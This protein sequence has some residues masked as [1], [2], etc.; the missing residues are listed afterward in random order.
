[1]TPAL[2]RPA[3]PFISEAKFVVDSST[4]RRIREW[5]RTHLDPDPH[6]AGPFGDEYGISSLYFDT[7]AG[8]V[9]HRRGSFGRAKYRVRRYG[10]AEVAFLERKLRKPGILSKRR[11]VVALDALQCLDRHK[12]DAALGR[13]TGSIGAC[14]CG[15]R[16]RSARFRTRASPARR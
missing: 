9:F 10:D 15:S 12:T 3:R 5:A 11:T 1:M 14:C 13:H 8:D 4:G 7:D 6:G 2:A 16:N